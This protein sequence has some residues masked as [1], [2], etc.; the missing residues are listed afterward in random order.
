MRRRASRS[1][2]PAREEAPAQRRNAATSSVLRR[3]RVAARTRCH[4]SPMA[5]ATARRA[6]PPRTASSSDPSARGARALR[7]AP[8]REATWPLLRQ[9]RDL[10]VPAREEAR[11]LGRRAVLG[12]VVIDELDVGKL[13]RERRHRRALV[14]R[15]LI[16]DLRLEADGLRLRR[17]RPVV[18]LLR[19]RHVL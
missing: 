4:P 10:L 9:R 3:M 7:E 16:R 5:A 12:E 19:I 6:P 14:R 11:T 15:K 2:R 8:P 18:P 17:Q 13:R 1:S